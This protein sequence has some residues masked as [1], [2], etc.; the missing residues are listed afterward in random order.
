MILPVGP[1]VSMY[2]DIVVPFVKRYSIDSLNPA[3]LLRIPQLVVPSSWD[4]MWLPVF[5][6]SIF[7]CEYSRL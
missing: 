3:A 4:W 5:L 1:G 6:L 7:S 2:R